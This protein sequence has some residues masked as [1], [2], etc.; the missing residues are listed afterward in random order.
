MDSLSGADETGGT[1]DAAHQVCKVL[2]DDAGVAGACSTDTGS[3]C[4]QFNCL[5][6][7]LVVEI[8]LHFCDASGLNIISGL[9]SFQSFFSDHNWFLHYWYFFSL[10]IY[11]L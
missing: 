11:H 5:G 3:V 4:Q 9:C 1:L 10:K 2:A 6:K 8:S 7:L